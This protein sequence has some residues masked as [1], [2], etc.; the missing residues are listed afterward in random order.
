MLFFIDNVMMGINIVC[1]IDGNIFIGDI[2][3]DFDFVKGIYNLCLRGVFI[4]M[5]VLLR[6]E[7]EE[8]LLFVKFK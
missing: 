2:V 6:F 8:I 3:S 1:F 7:L 5:L 4:Y